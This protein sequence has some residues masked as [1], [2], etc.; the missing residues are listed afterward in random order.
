MQSDPL[1]LQ[2]GKLHL[3]GDKQCVPGHKAYWCQSLSCTLIQGHPYVD[4]P[5]DADLELLV[6]QSW[7]QALKLLF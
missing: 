5:R 7:I 4:D 1:V 3:R 6:T 2:I